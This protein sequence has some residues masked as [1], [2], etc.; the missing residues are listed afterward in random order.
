MLHSG[1]HRRFDT[2]HH[3]L[4]LNEGG[5][6]SGLADG[7]RWS[8]TWYNTGLLLEPDKNIVQDGGMSLRP[9]WI[10]GLW[11]ASCRLNRAAFYRVHSHRQRLIGALPTL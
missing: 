11:N 1:L 5:C 10:I 2:P 3:R 4:E 9:G 6:A 7:R 8:N